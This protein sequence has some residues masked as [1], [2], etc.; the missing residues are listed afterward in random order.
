MPYTLPL[1]QITSHPPQVWLCGTF[2]VLGL[3]DRVRNGRV[4]TE[5]KAEEII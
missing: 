4:K 3:G 5:I 1:P 2:S